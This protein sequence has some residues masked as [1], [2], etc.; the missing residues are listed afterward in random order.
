MFGT[1][2]AAAARAS[3]SE[4]M[5]LSEAEAKL[6]GEQMNIIMEALGPAAASKWIPV[7]AAAGTIANVE[8]GHIQ[9]MRAEVRER[10]RPALAVV[11]SGLGPGGI[12]LADQMTPPPGR[13]FPMGPAGVS[14]GEPLRV[15]PEELARQWS[16][17]EGATP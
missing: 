9:A 15:T 12:P 7:V 1:V 5:L 17:E 8:L 13:P 16:T 6:C 4:A 14:N 3:G 10:A 11:P 2:N